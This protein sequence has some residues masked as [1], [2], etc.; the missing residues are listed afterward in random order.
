[1]DLRHLRYFIAVAEELHFG[2][3]AQRLGMAQPPLSQQ[4]KAFEAELGT[5]LFLRN[6]RKVE[7]TAAGTVL[8]DDARDIMRRVATLA[9]TAR[10]AAEGER[11]RLEIAFTGS[12]PFNDLMPRILGE[13]RRLYPDVWVSMREMSTGSQIEALL[14]ER[15]DIGFAR[16]A[17]SGLPVGIAARRILREPLALVLPTGHPLAGRS[18]VAMAEVADEPLVMHPRHIGTGLYDKIVTL[19]GRAGYTP[20]MG[21]EAHQMSTMVSLVGAGMGLAVVPRTMMRM[22]A[23]GVVF[24]EIADEQAFIDLLVIH[25]PGAPTMLVKNFL[26]VVNDVTGAADDGL[27]PR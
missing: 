15:L 11:G 26:L 12:V 3:A 22:G 13:F 10:A 18:R 8:L 20:R 7:L 16:P 21:V 19:C 23:G 25:R 9:P 17:D 14:E 5:A 1:M 4:I 27:D 24:A 6:R 2:R